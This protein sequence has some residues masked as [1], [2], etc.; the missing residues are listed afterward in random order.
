MLNTYYVVLI[1]WV[2]NAFF[3]S[4]RESSP[5]DDPDLDG[6]KAITYFINDIIGSGTVGDDGRATRMVGQNVGFCA[7]VWIIIY[8]CVAFGVKWTGR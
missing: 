4:F 6:D 5:W 8:F 3:D 2:A 7:M 1:A